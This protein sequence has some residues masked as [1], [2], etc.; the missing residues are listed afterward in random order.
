VSFFLLAA[1]A[2]GVSSRSEERAQDHPPPKPTPVDTKC[3]DLVPPVLTHRV[4]ARY[5]EYIRR[6]KWEG[7]V[8]LEGILGTDGRI[9]DIKVRSS[10]GKPLSDLAVEAV[11]QWL[12]EPAYCKE[13]R[14]PVRVYIAITMTFRLNRR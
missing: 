10:P 13:L 8:E 3:E 1:V 9:S 7:I 14:K 5:P 12:Y 2:A 6:Q 4:E 11:T